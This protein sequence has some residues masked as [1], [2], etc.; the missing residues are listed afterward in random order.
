LQVR[1][2]NARNT[3]LFIFSPSFAAA[4]RASSYDD[5]KTKKGKE[6]EKHL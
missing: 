2:T 6:E 3:T 1:I 4:M 5:P